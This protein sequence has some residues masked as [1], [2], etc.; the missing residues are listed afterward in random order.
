M[1][2]IIVITLWLLQCSATSAAVMD[3][4]QRMDPSAYWTEAEQEKFSALGRIEC[5]YPGESASS[6]HRYLSSAFIVEREDTVVTTSH[7]FFELKSLP[8]VKAETRFAPR[9]CHFATYDRFG[10]QRDRIVIVFAKIYWDEPGYHGDLSYDL[11]IVKL[12]RRPRHAI[13]GFAL[14]NGK[15]L[16]GKPII[17]VSFSNDVVDLTRPRKSSGKIYP[18]PVN[19]VFKVEDQRLSDNKRM[20]ATSVDSGHGS[21]GGFYLSEKGLVVGVHESS[22]TEDGRGLPGPFDL[23]KPHYNAGVYVDREFYSDVVA[24]SKIVP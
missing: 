10:K 13:H 7:A 3:G 20:F 1:N 23:A 6:T 24:V 12:E 17:L 14:G 19:G 4:D 5:P 21:S 16:D 8:Q 2:K 22:I 15:N 9:S 11:A 18:M